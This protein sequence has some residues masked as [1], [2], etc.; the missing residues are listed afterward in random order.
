MVHDRECL[1]LGFEPD[2]HLP[3][4]HA[5]FD[6]F[7]RNAAADRLMLLRHEDHAHAPFADLLEQLVGADPLTRS[8]D[9][10]LCNRA[11]Y[12]RRRSIENK[13]LLALVLLEQP[14]DSAAQTLI[15]R[16]DSIQIRRALL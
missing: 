13:T 8:F 10:R 9:R 16:A 2:D 7:E 15:A 14:L 6:N 12:A 5:R 1:P 4:V 3:R 11:R